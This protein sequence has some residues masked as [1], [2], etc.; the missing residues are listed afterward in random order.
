LRRL[1]GSRAIVTGAASGIGLAIAQRFLAEGARVV[2]AYRSQ[3]SAESVDDTDNVLA[4]KVD[5]SREDDV[6]ALIDRAVEVWDGLD[7]MVNNAGIGLASTTP[8]TSERDWDRVMNVN[9]KG[10]FF[11]MKHAIPAIRDSGG[12]SVINICSTA[13]LVGVP[14]RAAYSASKGGV[15]ALTRA[16]AIDHV[17]EGVRV[18]CI[19]PGTTETPWVTRITADVEDPAAAR[20]NMQAR[21]PHGR[22]VRPQEVAALAAYLASDESASVIGAAMVIDGGMTAQ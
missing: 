13:A 3:E 6:R 21:Q 1:E 20:A 7:V 5:V 14:N 22:F 4:H 19:L 16:A 8:E 2:F 12:G 9:L 10:V 11:G 17:A 15:M 18:N